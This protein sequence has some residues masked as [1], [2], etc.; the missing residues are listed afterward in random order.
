MNHDIVLTTGIY[1]LIKDSIRRKKVSQFVENQLVNQLKRAKQVRR[2]ELPL[3]VVTIDCRVM[4]K[5]LQTAAVQTYT[6]VEPSKAKK[7][8]HTESIIGEIGLAFVGNKIGDQIKWDFGAG[9]KDFEIVQ[10]ERLQRSK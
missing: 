1:D 9:E 5:D 2:K 4:V 6:F 7:R 10:V 8:N 3:D